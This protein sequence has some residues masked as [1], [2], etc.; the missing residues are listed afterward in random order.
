MS[1]PLVVET[2]YGKVR[3]LV[4]Q[5]GAGEEKGKRKIYSWRGV[6]YAQ[7]PVGTGRFRAPQPLQPWTGVR[8]ATHY[9]ASPLQLTLPIFDFINQFFPSQT[10]FSEDC[11]YLNIWS[12]A[13]DGAKRPV[14]FWIHGG[15]YTVGSG[16]QYHGE[17]LAALGD[18]VV[19]TI[20]YRLGILG[21]ANLGG[22]FED[23]RFESNL[24]LRDQ[25]AALRW[26][27]ENIAQFGGD[28]DRITIAG[29]SAGAGSVSLLMQMQETAGLYQ[30][31][32]IESG[33][34]N[35]AASWLSSLEIV[36]TYTGILDISR[37]K[38]DKLWTLPAKELLKAQAALD[39]VRP[40]HLNTCPYLDGQL[41]P[42]DHYRLNETPTSA[43]PLLTGTNQD[44]YR[45]FTLPGLRIVPQNRAGIIS[46]LNGIYRGEQVDRLLA[47]YPDDS[48]GT[49]ELGRDKAFRI[50][51]EQFAER[52]SS[53]APVWCYHFDFSKHRFNKR[54]RA[55]HGLE[56]F[57][58]WPVLKSDRSQKLFFGKEHLAQVE[59]LAGRMKNY[60]L[61][62]VREGRP[63]GDWE[64]YYTT[65][66]CVYRFNSTDTQVSDPESERRKAWTGIEVF[67]I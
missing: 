3:G 13:A 32:I 41:L 23:E 6:P 38:R 16:K 28:P 58:I 21:F 63:G 11:L 4:E 27:R 61:N 40:E 37:D 25:I 42:A 31:A 26:V 43:V 22:L 15:A 30:G 24:G 52:H 62:F 60:W 29:E 17:E 64:P 34:P 44:E 12:P 7:P 39:K 55:F 33:A 54:L 57:F 8:D 14:L 50:P 49:M 9:G 65:S 53:R 19:V 66:R 45:L 51:A 2:A 36:R 46:S 5:E 48:E 20:N 47:Q 35:Q 1:D 67:E 56:L 59:A 10:R 18:I